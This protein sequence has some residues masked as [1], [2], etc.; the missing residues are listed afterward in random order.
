MSAT[1]PG[2]LYDCLHQ[3]LTTFCRCAFAKQITR[4]A[5]PLHVRHWVP[6]R[7]VS[8][9]RCIVVIF[10]AKWRKDTA[11]VWQLSGKF[12]TC[13]SFYFAPYTH[14]TFE[15]TVQV[16][17]CRIMQRFDARNVQYF[18]RRVLN[19]R[20]TENL[21]STLSGGKLLCMLLNVNVNSFL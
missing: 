1:P 2:P 4:G 8:V 18:A 5:R 3:V 10:D 6:K 7:W 21:T 9:P 15:G 11:L 16:A 17:F 20:R 13:F 12:Y 14:G 19:H